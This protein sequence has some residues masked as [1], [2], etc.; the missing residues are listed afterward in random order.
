[1]RSLG[2]GSPPPSLPIASSV[3]AAITGSRPPSNFLALRRSNLGAILSSQFPAGGNVDT[4]IGAKHNF[5]PVT[6]T[7][8]SNPSPSSG[9]SLANL[10]GDAPFSVL[11]RGP[12][13]D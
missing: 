11:I 4:T 3:A 2:A 7:E 12:D 6:G 1:M 10:A 9:E 13:W 8:G 5:G